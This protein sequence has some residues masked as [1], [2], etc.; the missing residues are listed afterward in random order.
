MDQVVFEAKTKK[1]SFR[2]NYVKL[3]AQGNVIFLTWGQ[4][5]VSTNIYIM[6]Y[7]NSSLSFYLKQIQ[8]TAITIEKNL[9]SMPFLVDNKTSEEMDWSWEKYLLSLNIAWPL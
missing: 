8:D 5:F 2:P 9:K 6:S 7:M 3:W 1:N 4:D